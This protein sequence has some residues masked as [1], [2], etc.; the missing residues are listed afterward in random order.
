[1]KKLLLA[2]FLALTSLVPA[3][4]TSITTTAMKAE[5]DSNYADNTKWTLTLS[6]E[7]STLKDIAD[8]YANLLDPVTFASTFALSAQVNSTIAADQNNYDPTGA[9]VSVQINVDGGV[10]NR[11][12]TG[13]GSPA[14][15]RVVIINN[16]GT[17]NNLLIVNQSGSST[18]ANRFSI[19]ADILIGINETVTFRYDASPGRWRTL[20][21]YHVNL[22]NGVTNN[23]PVTNL[24]SGTGATSSTFF[25]GDGVWS[26]TAFSST[27]GTAAATQGGTGIATYTLGDILYSSAADTLAKLA[28]STSATRYLSNTGT[29]NIPA[30]AQINLPDGVTGNLPVANLGSG[31]GAGATTF[32]RGDATWVAALTSLATTYPMSGGTITT[33]GTLT[34][35][36]PTM[37]GRLTFSSA[38]ALFFKPYNGDVIKINGVILQIPSAGIAGCGNPNSV[39]LNGT[40]AQTLGAS[41]FYYVYAFSNSGT[42]TCDFRTGAHSASATA[43]NIG[44]EI[45]TGDDTR[46]LVG[47]IV[48]NGS[49]QY[50]NSAT[51]ICV[52]SWFNRRG[53]AGQSNFSTTRTST[54]TS[55]AE[56]NSE[57]RVTFLLWSDESISVGIIGAFYVSSLNDLGSTSIGFNGTTNETGIAG[58][59]ASLSGGYAEVL[60]GTFT[61]SGL[62]EAQSNYV[63]LLG[64]VSANTG[65]WL[66]AGSSTG[67]TTIY[68][69]VPG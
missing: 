26:Q 42:V 62:T 54:S 25:R 63:T 6:T 36:M 11:S 4:A 64:R 53:L 50:Q 41:T 35:V 32:F 22:S 14:A 15:G 69:R 20:S 46:T 23:L 5:I 65:T 57:I 1:M 40:G 39:F 3:L 59:Q 51:C 33:T 17:T 7:R 30:W 48:T 47:M 49:S 19:G 38:T 8:S 45:L 37:S 31:T 43:G 9:S 16:A 21:K 67:V 58:Q 10:A 56:I 66:G 18:A 68:V 60:G 52:V 29:S 34:S 27:L 28:K 24:N 44:T 2:G 13:L 61:K 55:F 12:I